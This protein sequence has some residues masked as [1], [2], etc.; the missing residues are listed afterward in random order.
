MFSNRRVPTE[1]QQLLQRIYR[2]SQ[3][4]QVRQR[5]HCIL[6]R[7]RG[8]SVAELMRIFPMIRSRKT[9]YNWFDEWERRGFVGLYNRPG[10]GWFKIS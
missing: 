8:M 5:A 2:Q 6:L 1:S 4:P 3:H 7:A 10:R 9:L